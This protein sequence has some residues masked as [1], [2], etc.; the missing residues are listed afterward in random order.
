M[1][2]LRP[3]WRDP[4]PR[5]RSGGLAGWPQSPRGPRASSAEPARQEMAPPSTQ[6]TAQLGQDRRS[7]SAPSAALEGEPET[8]G[9]KL[10]QGT[11]P[12]S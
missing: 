10:P 4:R 7:R 9:V 1:E 6:G 11:C 3:K 2:V 12:E 5:A 8:T